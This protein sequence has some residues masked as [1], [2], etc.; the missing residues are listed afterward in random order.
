MRRDDFGEQKLNHKPYEGIKVV[1]AEP[2][3]GLRKEYM[4]VLRTLGCTHIIETGNIKDVRAALQEGGVD[5]VIGDTTLPEG[6]L[7][8]VIHQVRHGK[9]GDN[10]FIIAMVLVSKSD[11]DVIQR[12]IDSGADDILI[13]PLDAAQLRERLMMFTRGRKQFVVTSDYIGP[14]RRSASRK[15]G[16]EI[17]K[18]KTPNPL[19]VRLNGSQ[20]SG[21]MRRAVARTLIK[22]NEQKVERHAYSVHWLM[23]RL[24]ELK[25]G[26]ISGDDLNME[27]QFH[28]LN[29]IAGDIASRLNGTG[30]RHASE[31]CMT[32]ER[33]TYLLKES[34]E[35]AGDV[36]IQLLG[37]LT[38]VIKRKCNGNIPDEDTPPVATSL[39]EA[40]PQPLAATG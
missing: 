16:L 8:E 3:A 36:E 33:M 2:K 38:K 4:G 13:K 24:Q 12:V 34:P 18:I 26:E 25:Q 32:L 19:H 21:S 6:D 17:P 23:D 10:P 29:E 28:R 7:S 30:Y 1:L 22:V 15:D 5:V 11:K 27:E 31:M 20:G 40:E 14:D 37:K 35:L 39:P 9:I